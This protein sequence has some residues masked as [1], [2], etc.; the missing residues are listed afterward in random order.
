MPSFYAIC[1]KGL[2]LSWSQGGWFFK[3]LLCLL[4]FSVA[5][6]HAFSCSS[7]LDSGLCHG[8]S[9]FPRSNVATFGVGTEIRNGFHSGITGEFVCEQLV[10]LTMASDSNKHILCENIAAT[11]FLNAHRRLSCHI[12]LLLYSVC[13]P[14]PPFLFFSLSKPL[15]H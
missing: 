3:V 11:V 6:S 15:S 9:C 14:P 4:A 7:P 10:K 12:C 2:F 8:R 1:P 13:R 5:S